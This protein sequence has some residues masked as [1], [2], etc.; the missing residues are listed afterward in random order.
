M[1]LSKSTFLGI[2]IWKIYP[3][4]QNIGNIP[5]CNIPIFLKKWVYFKTE[6]YPKKNQ[7]P[8]VGTLEPSFVQIKVPYVQ[9]QFIN[10]LGKFKSDYPKNQSLLASTKFWKN[11]A[12]RR[13]VAAFHA[14]RSHLY[15]GQQFRFKKN[16]SIRYY[17]L[18]L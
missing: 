6:I 2:N 11:P 14:A 16:L 12:A 15:G 17:Y 9:Q 4:F 1:F 18:F 3:F 10:N 13:D 7:C 8:G 5:I